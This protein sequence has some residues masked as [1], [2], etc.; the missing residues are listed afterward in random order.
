MKTV[1]FISLLFITG[2]LLYLHHTTFLYAQDS[3]EII[4]PNVTPYY[5]IRRPY[6]N[7]PATVLNQRGKKG[8]IA[9]NE[10]ILSSKNLTTIIPGIAAGISLVGGAI[11]TWIK[12]TKKQRTFRAYLKKVNEACDTYISNKQ[13]N[14]KQQTKLLA[15]LKEN[16][17][18]IQ[19]EAEL[20]AANKVIDQEH[21][22]VIAH[23]IQKKLETL[24]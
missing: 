11:L 13:E 10:S 23:H 21:V 4:I 24:V 8:I 16:L 17:K 2:L 15:N 14:P 22:T 12:V 18:Q 19:E 20:A 6:N 1:Y 9:A 5:I 3:G 7:P